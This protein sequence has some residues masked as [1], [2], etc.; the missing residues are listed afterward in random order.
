MKIYHLDRAQ[1]YRRVMLDVLEI[2]PRRY[3]TD[4]LIDMAWIQEEGDV[5]AAN[6]MT[7]HDGLLQFF[8]RLKTSRS[9]RNA[10]SHQLEVLGSIMARLEE[11]HF[12]DTGHRF[13]FKTAEERQ[14]SRNESRESI[15]RQIEW[16]L[17]HPV[18]ACLS[19]W[20]N[21]TGITVLIVMLIAL[22]VTFFVY[23]GQHPAL[24]S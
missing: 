9:F 22:A 7:L 5:L 8:S 10:T 13:T 6:N 3:R 15:R 1:E 12:Y 11:A 23:G 20:L 17:K 19:F 2:C 14:V 16:D 18:L 4:I 21:Q 24:S